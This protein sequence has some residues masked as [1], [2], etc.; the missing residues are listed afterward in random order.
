MNLAGVISS[1]GSGTYSVTRAA[2]GNFGTVEDGRYSAAPTTT[3]QVKASI[4]PVSEKDLQRLP[5]GERSINRI[6]VFTATALQT[7]QAP[8][9]PPADII[10]WNGKQYQIEDSDT[11]AEMAGYNRYVARKVGQ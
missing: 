7:S 4:Q 8:D 11:W 5:E 2:P 9:G 10:T 3:L 6:V 1:L